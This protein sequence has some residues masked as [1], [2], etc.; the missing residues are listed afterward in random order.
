VYG[1]TIIRDKV[2]SSEQSLEVSQVRRLLFAVI[3]NAIFDVFSGPARRRATMGL[4]ATL[5]FGTTACDDPFA[6]RATTPVR[7]GTFTLYAVSNS[8]VNA[9]AAFNILFFTPLRLE[10]A[11]GFDL[12]FDIDETG[13]VVLIPVRLVGGGITLQRRVGVQKLS[14]PWDD[15]TRAPTGGYK[16]DSTVTLD[17]GEGALVEVQTD[18]CQFQASRVVYSKLRIQAIEPATRRIAF[19]I[20]YDPNCGFRSFLPGIPVN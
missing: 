17:V 13:K 1:R 5:A 6:P 14:V 16:Y 10:P 11:Y 4:V 18:A 15:M 9:P 7:T 20:A 19:E 3:L 2:K 12:V 8:P